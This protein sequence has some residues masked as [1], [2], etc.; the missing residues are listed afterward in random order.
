MFLCGSDYIFVQLG[1]VL[2]VTMQ[3][4]LN[5]V[6]VYISNRYKISVSSYDTYSGFWNVFMAWNFAAHAQSTANISHSRHAAMLCQ[7]TGISS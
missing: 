2:L 6:L 1:Y 5:G 4:W 3:Q 7:T